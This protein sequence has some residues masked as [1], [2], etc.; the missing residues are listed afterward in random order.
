MLQKKKIKFFNFV[1]KQQ[2]NFILKSIVHNNNIKNKKIIIIKNLVIKLKNKI[3]KFC[4]VTNNITKIKKN[5]NKN[6]LNKQ[7]KYSSLQNYLV[8]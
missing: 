6:F 1:K 4:P 7:L 8:K 3:K 5:I 2:K